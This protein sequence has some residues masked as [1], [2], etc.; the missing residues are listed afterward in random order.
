MKERKNGK[1]LF[2]A[3][4]A[5]V[6]AATLAPSVGGV[7]TGE[8][9]E[10]LERQMARLRQVTGAYHNE[11]LAIAGGFER[12][13]FCVASPDGGMGYHYVN[14]ERFDHV[15]NRDQPEGLLYAQGRNNK[16]VLT[17]V[18]Y[19]KV[20][21]DQDLSTN[22]DRPSLFGQPFDGPMPGHGP[23]MPVHYDLHVWVWRSNP[24]GIFAQWNPRVTCPE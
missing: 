21:A 6:T 12:E 18:E 23:G 2:A 22:A 4:A 20:D 7:A 5:M 11:A 19:F 15:V 8:T 3:V 24:D 9:S 10:K 13:D 16:R 1:R 14:A 17:G